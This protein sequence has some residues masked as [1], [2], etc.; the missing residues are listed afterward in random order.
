[1]RVRLVFAGIILIASGFLGAAACTNQHLPAVFGP[2]ACG[3]GAG[4]D[5]CAALNCPPGTHCSLTGNC[6]AYCEQEQLST[7]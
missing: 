6:T 4:P 2:S 7:H 3:T 1:M 5:R